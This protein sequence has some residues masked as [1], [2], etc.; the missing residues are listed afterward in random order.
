MNLLRTSDLG[1]VIGQRYLRTLVRFWRKHKRKVI[2]F[3]MPLLA[4]LAYLIWYLAFARAAT[5]PFNAVQYGSSHQA[6]LST[7]AY[8]ADGSTT[9]I[10]LDA[11]VSSTS[12]TDI[13][14]P[15]AEVRDVGTAFSD[16]ST[17]SG[18]TVKYDADIPSKRRGT[19]MVYDSVN[20]QLVVFGGF[21][22]DTGTQVNMNDVWVLS[23]TKNRRSQWRQLSPSGTA[24]S[25]RRTQQLIYDTANSRVIVY[26]GWNGS[27]SDGSVYAL[28]MT[29][30]SEAWSTLTTSGTGPTVRVQHTAIYDSANRRMIVYGGRNDGGTSLS[31]TVFQLTLPTSGTPTWSQPTVS[32]APSSGRE[33]HT[34]LY[35]AANHVAW[36]HGG[37]A[38][39]SPGTCTRQSDIWKLTLPRSGTLVWTQTNANC[40]PFSSGSEGINGHAMGYDPVNQQAVIWAGKAV[41]YQST[42]YTFNLPS[43]GNPTCTDHSTAPIVSG[44]NF[45]GT[46]PHTSGLGSTKGVYDPDNKRM[47]F[48]FGYDG[49]TY[50]NETWVFDNLFAPGEWEYKVMAPIVYK[51]A[52]DGNDMMFDSTN[53]MIYEFAGASRYS[54]PAD[55]LHVPETWR[56]NTSGTLFWADAGADTA[57]FNRE[58]GNFIYDDANQRGV[59]CF[60]LNHNWVQGDCWQ[61]TIDGATGRVSWSFLINAD[62]L[63]NASSNRWGGSAVY[64]SANDRMVIFGGENNTPV[65]LNDVQVLNLPAGGTASWTTPTVSGTAPT[66]RQFAT[67]AYDPVNQRAL[68][69]GGENGSTRNNQVWELTLPSSGSFAWRQLSPTGTAPSARGRGSMVYD[70]NS[71]SPRLIL[72]GGYDGTN[73]LNDVWQLTIPGSGDGAWSQPSV[74]G[75]APS[76]RRSMGSVLDPVNNRMIISGGRND[77]TFFSDTYALNLGASL[78]WSNLNPELTVPV[79]VPVSSLPAERY[80]W[81]I[82]ASGSVSGNTLKAAYGGNSDTPTA[83]TDF[84]TALVPTAASIAPSKGALS[85]GTPFTITGTG[86][87]PGD[88]VTIGGASATNVFVVNSTMITGLAPSGTAGAKD[89]VVTGPLG[90]TTTISGGFTYVQY[91]GHSTKTVTADFTA[92]GSSLTNLSTGGIKVDEGAFQWLNS[93]PSTTGGSIGAGTY[94]YSVTATDF[95]G[96]ETTRAVESRGITTTGSTSSIS[97]KWRSVPGATGYKL[98]RT[99]SSGTYSTPALITTI[100]ASSSS[101]TFTEISY[102]DTASAP[103]SGA[104]PGSNTTN[105]EMQLSRGTVPSS[106][107]GTF[108][109]GPAGP[110]N[111]S[112][113]SHSLLRPDG[114]FLVVLGNNTANT[115]IYDPIAN[116]FSAGPSIVGTTSNNADEGTHSIQRPDGKFL[117]II[118]NNGSSTS[119]YD[120]VNNTFSAGP[121]VTGSSANAVSEGAHSLQRPDGK[122]LVVLGGIFTGTDTSIYDPESNTFSPGPALSGDSL[123]GGHAI[124]RPD[125]KFLMILGGGFNSDIYDPTANSFVAGPNLS[126]SAGL[127]AHSVQRPDGKFLVIHGN[128]TSGTSIYDPIANSFAAGPSL[129]NNAQSGAHSVQRPD[130]KFLVIHGGA[131][132][133]TSIYDPIANSFSSGPT[134]VGTSG[135]NAGLGAHSL[136]RPDGKYIIIQG[137]NST[138]TSIY[139]AGWNAGTT[140]QNG[141]VGTYTSEDIE[142]NGLL[143]KVSWVKTLDDYIQSSDGTNG[144]I[145]VKVAVTQAGLSSAAYI[146]YSNGDNLPAGNRWY[147][148]KITFRRSVTAWSRTDHPGAQVWLGESSTFESRQFAT[149]DIQSVTVGYSN[150]VPA[151]PT[152]TAPTAA[153]TGVSTNPQF[154][155]YAIDAESDPLRYQIEVCSTSNCSAIVRTIDQTVSQTG[156]LSQSALSATAYYSPGEAVHDYQNPALSP[157]TQYWWRASAIDPTGTGAWS[158]VSGIAT[159]TTGAA[160]PAPTSTKIQGGTTLQGG[161][162]LGN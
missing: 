116:T 108:S 9:N 80:H 84:R 48:M 46:R 138:N 139:D 2:R 34:M 5:T 57:P 29:P 152:L 86:F 150:S 23:L 125:G 73:N 65:R 94:Y 88:S 25:I 91:Y 145:E 89:V 30:G 63:A 133:A 99:T 148:A 39:S 37:C 11:N 35:D 4:I 51:R 55:A 127:G 50:V 136:Q 22:G 119:I 105:G 96:G 157:N 62:S 141:S 70:P 132:S 45:E 122:F 42:V 76:V 115:A 79:S 126:N 155:L 146:N 87:E 53:N 58:F 134:I 19:D 128:A 123:I 3:G 154:R 36:M 143:D 44:S 110:A 109:A 118:G 61:M 26:G 54:A 156:W 81:Q 41:S 24:P 114:K 17:H 74:S 93:T 60:G 32:G 64:D 10:Y 97:L 75:T 6:R 159:F 104:P 129:S 68:F 161:T 90:D 153:A 20:K 142:V 158:A 38:G 111:V 7:G 1:N 77:S 71:G 140:A 78:S 92:S 112:I 40:G 31:S 52:R 67:A 124:Q 85:G 18:P 113:G 27:T 151:A 56:L 15:Y 66:V 120:P 130:G 102:T 131:S 33:L 83:A 95:G 160:A 100:S 107:A 147:K 117:V 47:I 137:N 103:S 135:N 82:W 43:S 14:T 59:Y 106:G 69:F 49:S 149:P 12:T 162:K 121:T 8:T 28:D 144:K 13:F 72:F 16:A 101:T 21:G 98:Y